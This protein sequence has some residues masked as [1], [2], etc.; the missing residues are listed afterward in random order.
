[1]DVGS[2]PKA[3]VLERRN[4]MLP[5]SADRSDSHFRWTSIAAWAAQEMAVQSV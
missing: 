4:I 2:H 3:D 1:M 5:T